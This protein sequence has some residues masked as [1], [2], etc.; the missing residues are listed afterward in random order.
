MQHL[1]ETERGTT[2]QSVRRAA[3]LLKA[4]DGAAELGVSELSRKVK[5]HKSTVSRLLST[6][7]Q[8]GLL[9]RT[10]SG[11]KYRLGFELLRLAG[12]V[13]HFGDLRS[14]AQPV[15]AELAE[16]SRETVHLAVLDGDEV[17]NIEQVS[18]PHLVRDTNWVGRRT[19]LHC[20]ATGK[21]LLA[22]RPAAEIARMLAQP[23]ARRSEERRVGRGC[24]GRVCRWAGNERV[25]R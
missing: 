10:S 4:F 2:I 24:R 20:V 11:E 17:I 8:E 14:I 25:G 22:W 3:W 19:P 12:Q 21:A 9:E 18:G 7:E 23:L 16:L 13:T 5:L 1:S 6:L 15:L